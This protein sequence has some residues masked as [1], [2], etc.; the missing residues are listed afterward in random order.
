MRAH[1]RM[2]AAD[3]RHDAKRSVHIFYA[4][5]ERGRGDRDVIKKGM[6]G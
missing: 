2:L 6:H 3:L 5:G 4:D 1:A